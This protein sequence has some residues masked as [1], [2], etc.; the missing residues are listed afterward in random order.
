MTLNPALLAAFLAPVLCL[1]QPARIE[2]RPSLENFPN[3]ERGF[4]VQRRVD[5]PRS[6][7]DVL[8]PDS[9]RRW[10]S[11]GI[12]LV[13]L[14]WM[15]EEF[16]D[17]PLSQEALDRIAAGFASV[18]QAGFKVIPRFAYNFGPIG[19]PDAPAERMLE[20]LEQLRPLLRANADIIAFME[21]GFIGTWGEWHN[22]TH[23]LFDK[24]PNVWWH[25]L[26]DK[27]RAV[28]EKMFDVLPRDRMI[29]FRYPRVKMELF[30]DAP[31]SEAEAFSGSNKARAAAHNDCFLASANDRGTYTKD[32]E[33]E[34]DFYRLDNR[35]VP[36]GGETCDAGERAQPFIHCPV[37][38]DQLAQFRYTTLNISYHP[39]VLR[40]WQK[41]GCMDEIRRR[42]GYRFRLLD[43]EIAGSV[44]VKGKLAGRIGV[45][46]D[47]WGV[48][49]NPRPLFLVLRPKG[50]GAPVRLATPFDPRRWPAGERRDLNFDLPL[51]ASVNPGE[52][53][54]L[55][56]MPDAYESLRSR[57]E[58]S[59]RLAN[60]GVWD[61]AS[62]MNS[63]L[64]TVRVTAR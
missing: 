32:I 22:S 9:L 54:L 36:Q 64:R 10:R 14:Y 47:G 51:P 42:L 60:E 3:P 34:K 25:K 44:P 37:A 12:S 52:Y 28:V 2:Y 55:L 46:N 11:E 63:L 29:A 59:V 39:E 38:L 7:P 16:R 35:F 8:S 53:E 18:R 58:Y 62:G 48:M 57:P 24:I 33:R 50:G 61:E 30:G 6:R 4:Y 49:Y 17:K 5:L 1:A 41:E 27:S 23:G 21:A 45:I 56:E 20:H 43:S 13:R 19:A 31:L 26:N 40:L 15:I